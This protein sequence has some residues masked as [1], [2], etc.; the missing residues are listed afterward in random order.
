MPSAEQPPH[1]GAEENGNVDERDP[2]LILHIKLSEC[3]APGML[4]SLQKPAIA[5]GLLTSNWKE[6]E[7]IIKPGTTIAIIGTEIYNDSEKDG[8]R[9]FGKLIQ[10]QG[11]QLVKNEK[12]N[13]NR[14]A[15][16]LYSV[17]SQEEIYIAAVNGFNHDVHCKNKT[18]IPKELTEEELDKILEKTPFYLPKA[19]VKKFQKEYSEINKAE[20]TKYGSSYDE[21]RGL[22]ETEQYAILHISTIWYRE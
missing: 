8:V 20:Y 19:K 5:K 17:F 16:L 6:S 3:Q 13:R 18:G 7:F 11:E 4:Y 22:T 9:I 14:V 21:Y 2:W 12:Y 15:Q 1:Y 10:E